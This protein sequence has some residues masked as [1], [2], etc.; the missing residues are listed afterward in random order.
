LRACR[1]K[2]VAECGPDVIREQRE[3]FDVE[4]P[5]RIPA[6]ETATVFLG[7]SAD[8]SRS[9]VFFV[10]DRPTCDLAGWL[11]PG[12]GT[13]VVYETKTG[14]SL[15]RRE[16][17]VND[18]LGFSPDGREIASFRGNKVAIISVP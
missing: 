9:A 5:F 15:F 11:C 16:Y 6:N 8:Q 12:K 2:Q 10:K 18:A 1:S 7:R 14:K 4:A 3:N 17:P 13:L